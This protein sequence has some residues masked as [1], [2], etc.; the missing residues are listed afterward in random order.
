MCHDITCREN[1]PLTSRQPSL[2]AGSR[3][4]RRRSTRGGSPCPW[5]AAAQPTA[6]VSSHEAAHLDPDDDARLLVQGEDSLVALVALGGVQLAVVLQ[7]VHL[8]TSHITS[9]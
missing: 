6:A 4:A 8:A 2:T 1:E 5:P 3:R 7:A 9:C